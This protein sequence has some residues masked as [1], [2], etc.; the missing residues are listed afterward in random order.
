MADDLTVLDE[1][2]DEQALLAG[3]DPSRV[4]TPWPGVGSTRFAEGT[5]RLRHEQSLAEW[6][7][8]RELA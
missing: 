4:S 6:L 8:Q 3:L 2:V 7:V 1:I 5:R